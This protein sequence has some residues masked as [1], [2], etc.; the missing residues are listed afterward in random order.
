M[1]R[2]ER[3]I[4]CVALGFAIA[5]AR[6]LLTDPNPESTQLCSQAYDLLQSATW[7][8]PIQITGRR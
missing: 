6:A 2:K 8:G 1:T 3:I 5:W 4:L 7:R